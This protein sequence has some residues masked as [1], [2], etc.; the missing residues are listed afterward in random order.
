MCLNYPVRNQSLG[1]ACLSVPCQKKKRQ[2]LHTRDIPS[3]V[4]AC[5]LDRRRHQTPKKDQKDRR[6]LRFCRRRR[7]TECVSADGVS[8]QEFLAGKWS[9]CVRARETVSRRCGFCSLTPKCLQCL[10]FASPVLQCF[11]SVCRPLFFFA[12]MPLRFFL[13]LPD[14]RSQ[15]EPA[16]W[17]VSNR[18]WD[19]AAL[20]GW[21]VDR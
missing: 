4:G 5:L 8:M 19:F 9:H 17:G 14:Q 3:K 1:G 13:R 21:F 16:F 12:L 7:A 11:L 6:R 2:C 10:Q 20:N 15:S 18:F